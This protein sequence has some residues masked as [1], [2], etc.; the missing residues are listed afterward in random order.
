M[1]R[2]TVGCPEHVRRVRVLI[3]GG[4]PVGLALAVELGWRGVPCL[5]LEQGDGR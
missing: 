1:N 4:G 2:A 5:L 3:A